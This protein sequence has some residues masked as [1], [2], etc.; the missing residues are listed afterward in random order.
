MFL[1]SSVSAGYLAKLAVANCDTSDIKLSRIQ[2]S[3]SGTAWDT[4]VALMF[5]IW[6]CARHCSGTYVYLPGTVRGTAGWL[7][8]TVSGT[9]WDTA[10]AFMFSLPMYVLCICHIVVLKYCIFCTPLFAVEDTQLAY[11]FLEPAHSDYVSSHFT[12]HKK[13][14]LSPLQR[15]FCHFSSGQ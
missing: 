2:Y 9:A 15:Q 6:Y 14:T 5:S 7:L 12:T 1:K 11:W 8:C 3:V 4:A 13:H 10:V